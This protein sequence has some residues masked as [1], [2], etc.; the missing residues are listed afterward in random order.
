MS[1]CRGRADAW[2]CDGLVH[3][4]LGF[5]VGP[6]PSLLWRKVCLPIRVSLYGLV[7]IFLIPMN[8]LFYIHCRFTGHFARSLIYPSIVGFCFQ[9][10]VWCTGPR[11]SSG[12]PQVDNSHPSL[13]FYSVI[14]AAWSIV[15]LEYWKQAQARQAL[16]WGM[17]DYENDEPVRMYLSFD[18]LYYYSR[19]KRDCPSCRFGL[20][21]R[22]RKSRPLSMENR[23]C[24]TQL[25]NTRRRRG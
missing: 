10:L 22:A 17:T 2:A 9:F 8:F 1:Q 15:M 7:D 4:A 5:P 12:L 6:N 20:S 21:L 13:P 19:L 14:I 16:F 3:Y 23:T 18:S 11:G 24:T 25:V